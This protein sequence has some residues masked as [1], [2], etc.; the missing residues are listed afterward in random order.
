MEEYVERSVA[1]P[2]FNMMLIVAFAGSALALAALGLFGVISYSVAQR[3]HEIGIRR[4]L[5]A[6]DGRV[7]AMVL[8]QGMMLAAAGV[9][10]GLGGAF[11][12][13]GFLESLLFGVKPTDIMTFGSVV[14]VLAAVT[15]AA[16]YIPARRAA[17]VDPMVAVRYE[18]PVS[19]R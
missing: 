12:L 9:V 18:Y 3:T 5:G 7:I 11:V 15:F 4:A 14:A 10:L 17:H 19:S 8:R 13:T 16:C 2:R 1:R 6:A